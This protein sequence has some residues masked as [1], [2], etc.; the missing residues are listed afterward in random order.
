[1]PILTSQP[2]ATEMS[3][4]HPVGTPRPGGRRTGVRSWSPGVLL[5][6]G[7][8]LA[9]AP[10]PAPSRALA[11]DALRLIRGIRDPARRPARWAE[12]DFGRE[13]EMVRRHLAPVRSRRSLAA[14]FGREAFHLRL[15]VSER[16]DPS[17]IRLAYALRWMELGDG[18][19]APT[20]P[21]IAGAGD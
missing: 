8:I 14:S 6:P 5:T 19:I 12:S 15:T 13:I 3:T 21:M 16:D 1:M 7:D 17:P 4:F 9:P 18:V 2:E 10:V 11:L 20:W